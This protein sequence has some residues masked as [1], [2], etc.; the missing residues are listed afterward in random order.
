VIGLF[1]LKNTFEEAE[2]TTMTREIL[3]MSNKN[4]GCESPKYEL[5]NWCFLALRSYCKGGD[6]P[7]LLSVGPGKLSALHRQTWHPAKAPCSIL[8]CV[9]HSGS[10]SVNGTLGYRFGLE[11]VEGCRHGK[12]WW[13]RLT[14]LRCF[15]MNFLVPLIGEA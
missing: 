15:S 6:A 3:K 7:H 11:D 1:I 8:P 4:G 14:A 2:C 9:L 10:P 5:N 12:H 13:Q